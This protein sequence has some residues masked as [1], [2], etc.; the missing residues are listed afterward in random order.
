METWARGTRWLFGRHC[1][2]DIDFTNVNG[3]S[4]VVLRGLS[5]TEPNLKKV[6]KT[7]LNMMRLQ[8]T[9]ELDIDTLESKGH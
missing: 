4:E 6:R 1:R 2:T 5:S 3:A 8:W 7:V 9:N